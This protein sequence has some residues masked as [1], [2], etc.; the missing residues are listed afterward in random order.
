MNYALRK[1]LNILKGFWKKTAK[2]IN[3]KDASAMR[4]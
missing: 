2:N 3:E 4:K 1:R